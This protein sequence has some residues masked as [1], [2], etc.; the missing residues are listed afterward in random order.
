[1][2]SLSFYAIGTP[3]GQPRPRACIR[4][5]HAGMYDPGT[6]DAWKAAVSAASKAAWDGR[7]FDGPIRLSLT[8]WMPRPKSHLRSNGEVKPTAPRWHTSKPDLDNIEKAIKDAITTAGVWKDDCLVCSVRKTKR[9]ADGQPGA[10]V[11]IEE[12]VE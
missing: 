6:A 11:R 5:R 9:Y 10:E 12:I 2:K 1:V 4:G 8:I 3:V 7:V